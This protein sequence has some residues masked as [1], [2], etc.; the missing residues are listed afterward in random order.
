MFIFIY[1]SFQAEKYCHCPK[2]TKMLIQAYK[3]RNKNKTLKKEG[4]CQ[5]KWKTW[6]KKELA[7]KLNK[8]IGVE[9]DVCVCVQNQYLKDRKAEKALKMQ[10]GM[11]WFL[12]CRVTSLHK[13]SIILL[14]NSNSIPLIA[15]GLSNY[16]T[17]YPGQHWFRK[18]PEVRW[19]NQMCD[20]GL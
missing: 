14:L 15:P 13:T 17:L 16:N 6:C 19:H 9:V 2:E 3:N 11:A 7:Q 8:I 5:K 4:S 20:A 12:N 18:N 10:R 1:I